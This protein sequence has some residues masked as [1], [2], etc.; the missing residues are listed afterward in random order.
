MTDDT[1]VDLAV[2]AI[3]PEANDRTTFDEDDLRKLADSIDAN[4]LAQPIT[5]R[6]RPDGTGY[7]LVAGERRW[8]AHKL[9]GRA[10]IRA[11]VRSLSDAEAAN[12]MLVENLAR[13]DLN[14]LEEGR[15]YKKRLDGGMT[16]QELA[17]V[18]GVGTDRI[19]FRVGMLTLSPYMQKLIGDGT[20]GPGYAAS[21]IGLDEQ[22]Q[23]L[24]LHALNEKKLTVWDLEILCAELLADQ[25][26]GS[27]FDTDSFMQI[28]EIVI[29]VTR[30]NTKLS[31][32]QLTKLVARVLDG[33]VIDEQTLEREVQLDLEHLRRV[34]DYRLPE[35]NAQRAS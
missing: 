14:P 27:M 20:L 25:N 13:K 1:V 15:A 7:W 31:S 33:L 11:L 5:V 35:R 17:K 16:V 28:E 2:D 8:R 19:Q 23:L 29:Q 18:A 30:K 10:T 6:P 4:G 22:R 3:A 24:A 9:L 12:I 26:Q 32:V 21:M 34:I